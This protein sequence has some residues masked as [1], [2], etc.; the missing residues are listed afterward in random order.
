V[1]NADERVLS[2]E[3]VCYNKGVGYKNNKELIQKR[4]DAFKGSKNPSTKRIKIFDNND[5]LMYECFGDFDKI[6]KEN[7]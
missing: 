2:E 5:V 6:C 1:K 4:R 3:L 7:N